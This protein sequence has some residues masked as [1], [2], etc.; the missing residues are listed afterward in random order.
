MRQFLIY[1]FVAACLI[2]IGMCGYALLFIKNTGSEIVSLCCCL[3][4]ML[5][6]LGGIVIGETFYDS[7]K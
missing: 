2:G 5:I 7:K 4:S 6:N 3:C 1:S